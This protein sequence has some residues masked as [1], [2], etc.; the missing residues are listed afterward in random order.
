MSIQKFHRRLLLRLGSVTLASF[1]SANCSRR[2]LFSPKPTIE[3]QSKGQTKGQTERQPL[4]TTPACGDDLATPSQTEGPFYTPDS[5]ER[6]SL[7]EPGFAGDVIVL[8]GQ[9]LSSQCVPI[10]GALVDCWHTDAQGEYD[11]SGY[12]F[13][14][15]QFT[16]ADGRYR[17][18]TILPGVYP[19][20]TR[21]FHVKVQ[22]ANQPALTT[23]LYF[24]T[25][26]ANQGDFLFNPSLL[27][28]MS[29]DLKSATFN[30]V[31]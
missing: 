17:I 25:E 8:T 20:R 21:H 9:V 4:P 12:R 11:N 13:R 31:I 3:D 15:H 27:M 18:E 29:N 30:F 6:Q 28:T 5:P 24:P 14:G 10:A 19:G 26:P 22:A 2:S 7:L 23:Q 1:V 16:D